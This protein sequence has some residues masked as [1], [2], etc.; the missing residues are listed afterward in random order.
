[1]N[2]IPAGRPVVALKRKGAE[3]ARPLLVADF[4]YRAWTQEGKLRHPSLKGVSEMNAK[5]DVIQA[6][7]E[8]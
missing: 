3:F 7:S 6:D 8:T 5:S 1:M 4:E 2:A